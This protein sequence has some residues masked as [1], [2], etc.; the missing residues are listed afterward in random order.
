M[1]NFP[2]PQ[3][4]DFIVPP[5]NHSLTDLPVGTG[6]GMLSPL[7]P[8][9]RQFIA[10]A[11]IAPGQIVTPTSAS[12]TTPVVTLAR[13]QDPGPFYAAAAAAAPGDT[14][15]CSM[16]AV[17]PLDTTTVFTQTV[18]NPVFLDPAVPGGATFTGG[19]RCLGFCL[20]TGVAGSYLFDTFAEA[21]FRALGIVDEVFFNNTGGALLGGNWMER[22]VGG[23]G[24]ET[25]RRMALG[26]AVDDGPET[27][28]VLLHDTPD[29]TWGAVRRQGV[30]APVSMAP[31]A[32]LWVIN[33]AGSPAQW[34][35]LQKN[36]VL[37]QAAAAPL[38]TERIVGVTIVVP[39]QGG[40]E[41]RCR[42]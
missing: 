22:A 15:L 21:N 5:H 17:L 12:G 39:A 31:V 13:L 11:A 10:G 24:L 35:G 14:I 33:I 3:H 9:Y 36:A 18:G 26:A 1:A 29:Q 2:K 25:N 37:G 23:A 30:V 38:D 6:P 7:A 42:S 20:A 34:S 16:Q 41:V 19:G 40:V 32:A 28:G 4:D 8:G 27:L